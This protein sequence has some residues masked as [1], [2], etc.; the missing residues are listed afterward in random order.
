MWRKGPADW[1]R[2][3]ATATE[4]KPQAGRAED[5]E[6]SRVTQTVVLAD[7]LGLHARPAAAIART[8][9]AFA[10]DVF[11][12]SGG[13]VANGKSLLGL[14]SLG[15]RRGDA[16]KI[17]AEGPDAQAALRAIAALVACADNGSQS[18]S[19]GEREATHGAAAME[20]AL[21]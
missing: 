1:R 2:E 4:G 16:V 20:K 11:V 5:R 21:V 8:A 9:A 17:A 3:D 10:A 12:E 15:I 7:A 18:P 19:P 13:L 14:L 6:G